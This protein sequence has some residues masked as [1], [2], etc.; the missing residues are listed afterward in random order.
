MNNIEK[1]IA[2]IITIVIDISLIY[3]LLKQN[4]NRF[5]YSFILAILFIHFFFVISIITQYRDMID[6]CHWG[7]MI[8]L[9]LAIFIK[10]N[11]LLILPFLLLLLLPILWSIF[12][13]C[14]INTDQ[15]NNNGDF[16][17][18]TFGLTLTQCLFAPIIIISLKLLNI[19]K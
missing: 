7:L 18:D 12:G 8:S 13:K 15:Q 6:L 1:N 4:L 10:N 16:F 14:I 3:I 5:D 2:A 9:G 11:F 17:Y 19:I